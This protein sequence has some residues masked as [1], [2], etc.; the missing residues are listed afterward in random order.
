MP[1]HD[2]PSG[3][4]ALESGEA[5]SPSGLSNDFLSQILGL[6]R[7]AGERVFS[8]ELAA[9]EALAFEAGIACFHLIEAGEVL[10]TASDGRQVLARPGDFVLLPQERAH[11]LGPTD[12]TAMPFTVALTRQLPGEVRLV[13]GMFRFEGDN[14]TSMLAVLPSLI[15]IPA[16]T[17][18]GDWLAGVVRTLLFEATEAQPGAAILASRMMDVLVIQAMR[19]WVRTARPEDRGWLGALADPRIS[20]VLKAI[21]D[22]PF[23]IRTVAELATLAGMSRSNF[24]ERFALLI[25]APPLHYQTRWRLLL[26]HGMLQRSDARVGEVGRHI[27]YESEAAFSRAYKAQFGNPPALTRGSLG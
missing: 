1:N 2:R 16:D 14:L 9:S 21:H 7:L 4:L 8:L 20:K 3:R 6:I 17:T 26:A 10:M 19:L 27:G 18:D 15:H 5:G 11:V 24:A 13:T 12:A 23:R 22:E 25:G